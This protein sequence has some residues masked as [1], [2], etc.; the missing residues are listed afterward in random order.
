MVT[1][2]TINY[3]NI[4]TAYYMLRPVF[5]ILHV[6]INAF[7]WQHFEAVCLSNFAIIQCLQYSKHSIIQLVLLPFTKT[8]EIYLIT[9]SV[10]M[11][12]LD[13]E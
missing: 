6:L 9:L 1:S 7:S 12:L 3:S 2:V 11:S 13:F 8:I 5:S 10:W 4:T